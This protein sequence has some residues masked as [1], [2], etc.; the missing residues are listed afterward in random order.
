MTQT[1]EQEKT[2][3]LVE[4]GFDKE[5]LSLV[6]SLSNINE[7]ILIKTDSEDESLVKIDGK[8]KSTT[9]A[10]KFSTS[11]E[12]FNFQGEEVGFY[13]FPEFYKLFKVFEDPKLYQEDDVK[14]VIKKNRKKIEAH[15]ADS[16]SISTGFSKVNFEDPD[17]TFKLSEEDF[18][19]IR[20]MIGLIGAE[21]VTFTINDKG[22]VQTTLFGSDRDNSYEETFD[23][24]E[25]TEGGEID[26][27]I[28]QE[29]FLL[30]P[31]G[32]YTVS[33]KEEGIIKFSYENDKVD[34]D[35]FTAEIEE[36]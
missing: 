4:V 20:N 3:K 8:N 1:L 23:I 22:E 32:N 19:N 18:K 25:L 28:S 17:L 29:L 14:F 7:K 5:V 6:H 30:A 21:N 27:T 33:I 34:L 31:L 24:T 12:N 36:G 9:I 13:D 26:I 10:Y 15:I 11:K 2:K 16:E 35:I